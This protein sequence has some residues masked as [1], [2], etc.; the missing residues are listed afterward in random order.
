[1]KGI[2]HGATDEQLSVR[3]QRWSESPTHDDVTLTMASHLWLADKNPALVTGQS[4][5]V[6]CDADAR[7]CVLNS[8]WLPVQNSERCVDTHTHTL[9]SG[10]IFWVVDGKQDWIRRESHDW[11][12]RSLYLMVVLVSYSDGRHRLR[13][14]LCLHLHKFTQECDVHRKRITH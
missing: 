6:I 5:A 4:S 13:L 12:R 8:D 3:Y 7:L 1:M 9:R 14:Q 2:S 10:H 11:C